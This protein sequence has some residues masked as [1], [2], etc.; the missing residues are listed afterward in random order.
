MFCKTD[1]GPTVNQKNSQSDRI[2]P[3]TEAGVASG[4]G[5]ARIK[6]F[7]VPDPASVHFS[8]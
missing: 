6:V 4:C 5:G 2:R 1:V 3:W 7:I 8:F